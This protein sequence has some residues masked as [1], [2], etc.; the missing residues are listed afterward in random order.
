MVRRVHFFLMDQ[1]EAV[2]E[3]EVCSLRMILLSFRE[4]LLLEGDILKLFWGVLKF[5]L[6]RRCCENEGD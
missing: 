2:E 3:G 1:A 6:S 4:L 5:V